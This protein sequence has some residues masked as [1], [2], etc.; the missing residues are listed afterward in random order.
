[1]VPELM[2]LPWQDLEPLG[3]LWLGLQQGLICLGLEL[4]VKPQREYLCPEPCQPAWLCQ[5]QLQLACP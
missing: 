2:E 5:E 3:E 4:M 1:M